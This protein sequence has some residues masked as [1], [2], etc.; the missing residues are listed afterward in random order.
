MLK[1]FNE[2]KLFFDD[3]YTEISVREY[4]KQVEISPPTASKLLKEY[5]REGLLISNKKGI[6]IYFR[7]NREGYIFRQ[8]ERIYWF[9]IL[10]PIT[11]KIH[12]NIAYKRIILFGSL[13][14]AENTSKSDVDLYLEAEKRKIDV[15][16]IQKL[17]KRDVQ[18]H[19]IDSMKNKNLKKHIEE[20]I[21]IR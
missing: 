12:E 10:Y 3:V 1:I 2:L 7:A 14:K 4:A 6:Y 20:G 16:N 13:V 19:F 18:L 15:L 9:I 17:L 8:L 21:I 5:E 11:E